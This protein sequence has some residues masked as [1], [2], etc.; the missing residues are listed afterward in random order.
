M[1]RISIPTIYTFVRNGTI[2]SYKVGG[3]RL[4]AQDEIEQ[5]MKNHQEGKFKKK[6][7][8]K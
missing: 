6:K 2:P 8:T 5:W 4:F 7:D 3:K 1:L